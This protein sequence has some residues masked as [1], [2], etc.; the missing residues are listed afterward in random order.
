MNSI[1][2]DNAIKITLKSWKAL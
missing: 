1:I 2:N